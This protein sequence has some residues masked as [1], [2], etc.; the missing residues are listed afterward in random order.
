MNR[1]SLLFMDIISRSC[2]IFVWVE[3]EIFVLDRYIIAPL[4]RST[5]MLIMWYLTTT[6]IYMMLFN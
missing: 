2:N 6:Y 4:P 5:Y 3:A 1:H